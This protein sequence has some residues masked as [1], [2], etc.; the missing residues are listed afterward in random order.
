MSLLGSQFLSSQVLGSLLYHRNYYIRSA[1]AEWH[2]WESWIFWENSSWTLLRQI[3]SHWSRRNLAAEVMGCVEVRKGDGFVQK[4][5]ICLFTDTPSVKF[6]CVR[7]S[8]SSMLQLRSSE[9][10]YNIYLIQCFSLCVLLQKFM[11]PHYIYSPVVA[12][13]V[14]AHRFY[15]SEKTFKQENKKKIILCIDFDSR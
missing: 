8:F 6:H 7:S 9:N 14:M 4:L 3:C 15:I 10:I 13:T 12:H 2:F 11:V 5:K 1:S